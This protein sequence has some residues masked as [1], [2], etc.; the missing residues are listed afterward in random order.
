MRRTGN[1]AEAALDAELAIGSLSQ[2]RIDDSFLYVMFY[3]TL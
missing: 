1:M 3:P 2:D